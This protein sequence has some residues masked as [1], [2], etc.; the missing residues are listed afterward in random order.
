[1]SHS[2]SPVTQYSPGS[3]CHS[4]VTHC[5]SPVSHCCLPPEG[6]YPVQQ[7]PGRHHD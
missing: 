6:Q 5:H 1:V 3:H 7:S 2:H 4:P